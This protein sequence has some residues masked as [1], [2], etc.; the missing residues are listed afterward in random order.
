MTEYINKEKLIKAIEDKRPL[1]WNDTT[2]ELAEQSVF[3]YII[4]LIKDFNDDETSHINEFAEADKEG[5]C[6]VLPCKVGDVLYVLTTDS[7]TG[8]KETECTGIRIRSKNN[9]VIKAPCPYDDW[10]SAWR[11]FTLSDFE[12]K[13][14]L[15]KKKQ[16]KHWRGWNEL[17]VLWVRV[18]I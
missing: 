12:K 3:D 8:I 1:N 18:K 13:Y 11:E 6:L 5:R 16:K 9:V 15:P 10:G 14:F 4:D 7:L 17:S 2:A